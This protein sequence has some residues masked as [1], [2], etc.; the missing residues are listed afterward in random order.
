MVIVGGYRSIQ[1]CWTITTKNNIGVLLKGVH[2][3]PE[4]A[5]DDVDLHQNGKLLTDKGD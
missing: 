4:H 2:E 3:M 1:D 5:D